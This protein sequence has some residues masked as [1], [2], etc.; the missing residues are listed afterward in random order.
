MVPRHLPQLPA[1]RKATAEGRYE[2]S[3]PT[4]DCASKLRAYK[5][6]LTS[7]LSKLIISGAIQFIEEDND[8]TPNSRDPHHIGDHVS[9]DIY[10][11]GS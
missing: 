4:C 3:K 10:E 2:V 11:S 8:A 5:E 1:S 9:L 7:E 6:N